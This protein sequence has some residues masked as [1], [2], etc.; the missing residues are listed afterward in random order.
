MDTYLNNKNEWTPKLVKKHKQNKNTYSL[1]SCWPK[2]NIKGSMTIYT[3]IFI[4]DYVKNMALKE[5]HSATKISQME[6]LRMK[7]TRF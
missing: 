4:G 1:T 6:L 2:R 7:G 5:H 3:G